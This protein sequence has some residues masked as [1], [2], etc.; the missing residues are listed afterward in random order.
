MEQD[1]KEKQFT[2]LYIQ[3]QEQLMMELIRKILN[4]DVQTAIVSSN[5]QQLQQQYVD[6]EQSSVQQNK[7][8]EQATNS[9]KELNVKSSNYEKLRSEYTDLSRKYDDLNRSNNDKE[10]QILELMNEIER[11]KE[12]MNILFEENKTLQKQL[13]D[14]PFIK[15]EK[16]KTK[17]TSEEDSF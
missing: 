3:K 7:I 15:K 13:E 2:L 9:I 1:E 16:P 14:S 4:N 10:K 8:V 12:E 5:F 11:Q 6:L 17:K